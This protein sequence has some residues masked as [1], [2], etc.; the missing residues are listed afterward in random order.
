MGGCLR[1]SP[2]PRIAGRREGEMPVSQSPVIMII[3]DTY[4]AHLIRVRIDLPCL[5]YDHDMYNRNL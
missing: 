2:F 5:I 4:N 3:G 1:P